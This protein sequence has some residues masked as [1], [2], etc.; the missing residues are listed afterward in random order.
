[1]CDNL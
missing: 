1:M